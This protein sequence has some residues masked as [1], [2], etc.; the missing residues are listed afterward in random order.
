[1]LDA[2]EPIPWGAV[3]N[4][5][6]LGTHARVYAPLLASFTALFLNGQAQFFA[7]VRVR[8]AISLAIDRE[9]LVRDVLRGGAEP[10]NGPIPP[11]SWAYQAQEYRTDPE[12]A[13]RLLRDA[14]WEDRDGDGV[15]DRD[16]LNFRFTLLVNVDDPQRVAVAQTVAQQLSAIGLAVT[17][18][19][20]PASTLERQLLDRE[21]T[22]AIYGWMSTSGD[23]DSFELWHSSQAES[24]ANVTGFRSRTVDVLL[25]QARRSVDRAER[26]SL[27]VEFQ[28]LFADYVPA[29]VL[30][31]PRY[32][33][34][35]SD[36]IGGID[37]SPLIAPEDHFRQLPRWYRLEG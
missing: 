10:G 5:Q 16:G 18:Q 32:C 37:A 36:R 3:P 8:Q 6:L 2:V 26:R 27:Y 13:K 20:V 14:G 23:P 15:V 33:F 25:E 29:I 1:A 21:F 22:A 28:R 12:M 11:T 4:R 19:P 34:V 17:V 30:Y 24:G 31:Y 35:V 7:D 9:G